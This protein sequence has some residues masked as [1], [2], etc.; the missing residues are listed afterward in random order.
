MEATVSVSH[1]WAMLLF[2]DTVSAGASDRVFRIEDI[3]DFILNEDISIGISKKRSPTSVKLHPAPIFGPRLRLS[4]MPIFVNNNISLKTGCQLLWWISQR[5]PLVAP[6]TGRWQTWVFARIFS[7]IIISTRR[8]PPSSCQSR[9][10]CQ[11]CSLP[12]GFRFLQCPLDSW[13]QLLSCHR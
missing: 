3:V 10:P 12:Y 5:T 9:A 2:A 11:S 13:L 7:T 4:S 6:N 8:P 1:I